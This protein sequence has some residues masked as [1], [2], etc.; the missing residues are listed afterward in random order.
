MNTKRLSQ[1]VLAL[2]LLTVHAMAADLVTARSVSSVTSTGVTINWT[3]CAAT[4]SQVNY[5]LDNTYGNQTVLDATLVTS[6]VV[7]ITGLSPGTLYHYNIASGL[8]S[9]GNILQ[10]ADGTFTTTGVAPVIT[11]NPA[12]TTTVCAGGNVNLVAAA[13]GT[14]APTVQWQRSTASGGSTYTNISGATSTTYSFTATA[15][16]NGFN[17]RAVF[18]NA[19][20]TATS[21]VAA[22]TVNSPPVISAQPVD[23]NVAA[24]A[25][26]TF[27]VT[28]SGSPTYQWQQSVA[29]GPWTN[30]G[31]ATSSSLAVTG[32]TVGQSGSR[33]QVLL[34]VGV[35][36]AVTS[37]A[38]TLTVTAGQLYNLGVADA[39]NR[40]TNVRALQNATLAGTE[41]VFTSPFGATTSGPTGISN[42]DYWLDDPTM[43]TAKISSDSVTPYDF[44]SSTQVGAVVGTPVTG[45]NGTGGNFTLTIPSTTIHN[46]HLVY[47]MLGAQPTNPPPEVTIANNL[48]ST[49]LVATNQLITTPGGSPHRYKVFY[50]Q[51]I[52]AGI[53]SVVI[54]SPNA[55]SATSLQLSGVEG[56]LDKVSTGVGQANATTFASNNIMTTAND[57]VLGMVGNASNRTFTVGAGYTFVS[58]AN[59]GPNTHFSFIE[60]MSTNSPPGSYNATGTASGAGNLESIVMA[61]RLTTAIGGWSTLGKSGQHSITQKITKSDGS[62]EIDTATFTITNAAAHSVDLA[63][64]KGSPATGTVTYNIYRQTG[65]CSP[66]NPAR[67]GSTAALTFTDNAVGASG[68]V[69]CYGVRQ[70]DAS[71]LESPVS[72]LVTATVP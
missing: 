23:Q 22:V 60:R 45:S 56:T 21:T 40:T 34:T 51:D 47:V 3:S 2:I 70:V 59:N 30:I 18:T 26:A 64:V 62:T 72:N 39:A 68:S 17:F 63:W 15:A 38:A 8:D 66:W 7:A 24:G 13:S 54:T 44:N 25:M 29:S 69:Y 12:A 35:C 53:T 58:Q 49:Y 67:I 55:A 52:P 46:F 37:S 27:S 33:Y 57:I 16:D 14:P 9:S 43:I 36:S 19:T 10:G 1:L 41:Y 6:H 11:T 5:G 61:F 20:G 42:V 71:T 28:A 48:S 4:S 31:G 65:A 32:T 50:L